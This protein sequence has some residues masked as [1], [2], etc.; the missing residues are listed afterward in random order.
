MPEVIAIDWLDQ[1]SPNLAVRTTF[2]SR[3]MLMAL[4]FLFLLLSIVLMLNLLIAAMSE[5]YGRTHAESRLLWRYQ[6][7][8]RVLHMELMS[9]MFVSNNRLRAGKRDFIRPYKKGQERY[10]QVSTC[11]SSAS[12]DSRP[13]NRAVAMRKELSRSVRMRSLLVLM[14]LPLD[15]TRAVIAPI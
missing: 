11:S 14:P 1:H 12:L 2:W 6:F 9:E 5:T 8:R 15:S 10:Y 13:R 4:F 7:A 3:M